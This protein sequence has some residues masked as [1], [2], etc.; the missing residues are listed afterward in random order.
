VDVGDPCGLPGRL[1]R[2]RVV[3]SI[4]AELERVG[5]L[6]VV[7]AVRVAD[8]RGGAIRILLGPDITVLGC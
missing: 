4:V 6:E 7:D 8:P 2:V 5:A 3:S 1:L